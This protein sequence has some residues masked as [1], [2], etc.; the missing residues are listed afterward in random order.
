MDKDKLLHAVMRHSGMTRQELCD[1]CRGGADGGFPGF[2]YNVDAIRFYKRHEGEIYE[3]LREMA[4][5]MGC[6]SVD[7]LTSTFN[8]KDMLDDPDSRKVLLAW[9]ALEEMAR[10]ANPDF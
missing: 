6:K 5:E 8:R 1:V 3:L 9:F 7:E 4:D 10:Y 2:T